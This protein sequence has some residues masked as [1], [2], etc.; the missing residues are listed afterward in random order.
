MIDR[1]TVV[2]AHYTAVLPIMRDVISICDHFTIDDNLLLAFGNANSDFWNG[3][4]T[5]FKYEFE[6]HR[7]VVYLLNNTFR[8]YTEPYYLFEDF[9]DNFLTGRKAS[10]GKSLASNYFL[11]QMPNYELIS[12][13]I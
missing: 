1:H 5:K 13:R 9:I 10:D 11:Q 6:Q 8:N 3:E 12:K 7:G 4:R 2:Q